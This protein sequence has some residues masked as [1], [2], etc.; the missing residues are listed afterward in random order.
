MFAAS[1]VYGLI[2]IRSILLRNPRQIGGAA[3]NF[4]KGPSTPTKGFQAGE[5]LAFGIQGLGFKAQ[6]LGF[7]NFRVYGLGF[8]DV[9]Q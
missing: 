8:R 1:G 3:C 4:G 9:K 7:W 5:H 6:G 2:G